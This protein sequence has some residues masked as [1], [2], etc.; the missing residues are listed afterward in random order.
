[1]QHAKPGVHPDGGGLYLQVT[2]SKT[3][4]PG[5]GKFSK[6]W[7]FRYRCAGRER[8]MGLGSLKTISLKEAREAAEQCRKMLREGKDPIET[9]KAEKASKQVEVAKSVTFEWC[10]IA[11]MA[12]HEAG[13]RNAKHREQW[14]NTLSTYVYPIIGKVPV[15]DVDTGMVMKILTP[16]WIAKNETAS[17]VRGRIAKILDW[18]TVQK[19]RA[20]ENPARWAG[21][22]EHLLAAR[23]KVHKVQNHPALP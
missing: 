7:I 19:H 8:E 12:A 9:R 20:G 1:V 3:K 5:T 2:E 17:R 22:L 10:A 13:W 15:Q 4:E 11:Y 16:I 23:G 14:H 21:H 6:S 18:A